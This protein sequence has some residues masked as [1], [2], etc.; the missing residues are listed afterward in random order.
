[1]RLL[2]IVRRKSSP[3]LFP[4]RLRLEWSLHVDVHGKYNHLVDGFE[5]LRSWPWAHEGWCF[6]IGGN[7][8][9]GRAREALEDAQL[10]DPPTFVGL[11]AAVQPWLDSRHVCPDRLLIKMLLLKQI[12][13]FQLSCS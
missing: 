2:V 7:Y 8:N 3:D 11:H 6:E 1:M 10:R 9:P 12:F 5:R 13:N 4:F